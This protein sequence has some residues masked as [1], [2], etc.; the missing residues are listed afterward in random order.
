MIARWVK[1]NE[2]LYRTAKLL[3]DIGGF[4]MRQPGSLTRMVTIWKIYT[5]TMLPPIRLFNICDAV[6]SIN[7]RGIPGDL[8][9]CGVWS[10]GS[11]ALMALWDLRQNSDRR[12]HAFDS[13]EGLPPPIPADNEVFESFTSGGQGS[14][15]SGNLTWTGLCQGDGADTVRA[16]FSRVGVPQNRTVLHVGWFQN[17]VPAA[18]AD[19]HSISI[20]RIDGDWYDSTK[21]CLDHLYDLVSP[22]GLIIIDDYGTFSGCRKAVDE[23][24]EQR[25]IEA[26]IEYI[27]D[28]CVQFAK[29][30]NNE[31]SSSTNI[32]NATL[33]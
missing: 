26:S 10:G 9:E 16:F 3:R 15:V 33:S 1:S 20:L 30:A 13:F 12:Y 17:T 19:I 18:T 4:P 29:P 6:E 11:I 5:K 25:N 14:I 31:Q 21:T 22:G 23:F 24:R 27:D 28:G 2:N 7:R 32:V 8:V